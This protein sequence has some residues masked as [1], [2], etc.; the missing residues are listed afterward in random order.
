MKPSN[1]TV[2]APAF[3]SLVF[4]FVYGCNVSEKNHSHLQTQLDSELS[5][6]LPGVLVSVISPDKGINWSGAAGLSDVKNNVKIL[7]DQTFRIA[8]VTK[9]FVAATILRL[10]EDNK[11]NLDDPI[12]MYVSEKHINILKGG[13]YDTDKITVRHLL[14]HSSG[15]AEHVNTYKYEP[16]FMK[17]RHQWSRTE[18]IKDL[19]TYAKPVAEVGEK[20]SYSDT[21]YALLG[22]IIEKITG[23]FMGDAIEDQLQLNKLGLKDTYMEDFDGDYSGKRIHQYL[24]DNDTYD[25]HPSFDYYGGGGLLST[26]K[27]LSLFYKSLFEHKVFKNKATLDT[28]LAPVKYDTE[29]ELDYRMGIWKASINGMDVYTHLGFWGTQVAYIPEIKT[30]ISTNYSRRW[31]DGYNAPIVPKILNA[32]MN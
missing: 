8:S 17:T 1:F 5:D 4:L 27:D 14:N 10:W 3:I 11:L 6:D 24:A 28:M 18:Q 23:K 15:L 31:K 20:F 19:V 7:P 30:A 25:W 16:D 2:K 29:P 12:S 9:T 22:E 32:I 21:G 13:G 26:T